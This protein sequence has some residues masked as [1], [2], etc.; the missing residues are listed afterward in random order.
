MART[1]VISSLR[2]AYRLASLAARRGPATPPLDELV[3]L[4]Y[5]RR[6][7]LQQS[8]VVSATA[9]VAGCAVPSAPAPPAATATP[10][11]GPSGP[12]R[13]AIIGAGVAGL[14]A[15]YKL[16]K[17]GITAKVFE[18]ANRT[19]GRMFTAT[20]LGKPFGGGPGEDMFKSF[21]TEAFGKQMAKAGGIGVADAVGREMLKLQGLT[22]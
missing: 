1:P 15:A 4:A 14:N 7:F 8:A 12:P 16:Q 20:D 3:D 19:G 10:S 2:R 22:E 9:L 18:G 17:A 6:R 13:I 11:G 5:S 21:M